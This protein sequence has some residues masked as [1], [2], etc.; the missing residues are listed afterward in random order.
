MEEKFNDLINITYVANKAF[1]L[2]SSEGLSNLGSFQHRLRANLVDWYYYE[3]NRIFSQK[4]VPHGL[5]T[6]HRQYY[7]FIKSKIL[8]Q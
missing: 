8:A 7:W 1:I 5:S 4:N 3:D 6:D 2:E